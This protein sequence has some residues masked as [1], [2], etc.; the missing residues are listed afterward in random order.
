MYFSQLAI[1]LVFIT[2]TTG[3][4]YS[5][6]PTDAKA[7]Y[8]DTPENGK[9]GYL[10]LLG[11]TGPG[12]EVIVAVSSFWFNNSYS[13]GTCLRVQHRNGISVDF[14]ITDICPEC[15]SNHLD[16]YT[17]GFELF[18]PNWRQLGQI[19]MGDIQFTQIPCQVTG[20]VQVKIKD[21]ANLWW[22]SFLV[23]NH[24]VGLASVELFDHRINNY[25]QLGRTEYNYWTCYGDYAKVYEQDYKLRITSVL[26]D[27]I[28]TTI[29]V[30]AK[31]LDIINTNSQFQA[32][33][34][35][36]STNQS[37]NQE[38]SLI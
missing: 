20:N 17:K 18:Q 13:C 35:I 31:E 15:I 14:M 37:T 6:Q 27:V 16:F 19:A 9:C 21:G 33:S 12:T 36:I 8:Y 7:T 22:R 26:G 29:P 28:T 3:C 2:I 11:R 1:L 5:N 23:F 38:T 34:S 10:D 4:P 24:R 32:G 25:I 30:S